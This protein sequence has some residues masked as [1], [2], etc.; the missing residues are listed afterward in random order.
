[1]SPNVISVREY[2]P[3]VEALR[4][5][6]KTKFGRLPVLD[7]N[8]HVSGIITKGDISNGLL[9]ALQ[10]GLSRRRTDPLPGEPSL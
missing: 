4:T 7:D 8:D 5:F 6:N 9:Y 10:R 3:V 2:D 1:M